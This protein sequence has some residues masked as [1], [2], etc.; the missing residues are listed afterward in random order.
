[1]S[2]HNRWYGYG[3]TEDGTKEFLHTFLS[4]SEVIHYLQK[5]RKLFGNRYKHY[6]YKTMTGSGQE[7]YL[8]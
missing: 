2:F 4:S 7:H 5:H 8:E 3:I 1:M 6:F